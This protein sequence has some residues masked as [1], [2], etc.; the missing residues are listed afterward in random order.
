MMSTIVSVILGA[1]VVTLLSAA[2]SAS[3]QPAV[4]L[5]GRGSGECF[6]C[7]AKSITLVLELPATCS[8]S[9]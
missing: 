5:S 9:S 1:T 3:A 6:R 2:P 7:A 4:D 8:T